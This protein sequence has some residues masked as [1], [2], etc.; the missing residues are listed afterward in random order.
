MS[1]DHHLRSNQPCDTDADAFH[2]AGLLLA[3]AA[4]L[5]AILVGC[6]SPAIH[7]DAPLVTECNETI[8]SQ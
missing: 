1:A 7:V 3:V 2:A 8:P 5:L 6:V 4:V